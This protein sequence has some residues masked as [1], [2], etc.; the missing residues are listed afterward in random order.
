MTGYRVQVGGRKRGKR[1]E[2]KEGREERKGNLMVN[3]L[4]GQKVRVRANFFRDRVTSFLTTCH[5]YINTGS[6]YT[7]YRAHNKGQLM[8]HMPKG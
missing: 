6:T 5:G 3:V 2:R 8:K 7:E 1:E 4:S